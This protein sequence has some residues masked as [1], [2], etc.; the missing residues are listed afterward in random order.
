M[1]L[2]GFIISI[3]ALII[4]YKKCKFSNILKLSRLKGEYCPNDDS[5]L[6]E[7]WFGR[8]VVYYTINYNTPHKTQEIM[9]I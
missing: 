5:F 3:T 6:G 4:F 9:I 2:V 1:H 7:G 8:R